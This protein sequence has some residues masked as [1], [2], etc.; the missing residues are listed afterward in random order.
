MSSRVLL[1]IPAYNCEKQI[2]RVL[3]QV[4]AEWCQSVVGR[5]IVV[6]NRST[7]RTGEVVADHIRARGDN[8]VQLLLNNEN[9]GLGGSHK[10]A[11][12]YAVQEGYDWLV[13]LHGDDQGSVADFRSVLLQ[14]DSLRE[15]AV[16]GS[17]FMS[18]SQTP[19]YSRFRIFGN[20]LF[21]LLYSLC[22]FRPIRDLGAGLNLYRVSSLKD[23]SF[24]NYPDNLTFNCVMVC[25]QAISGDQ[26]LFEPI[27]WR[28]DD[29]I[30][31]VKMVRQSIQT[32]KIALSALFQ[33]R[34]FLKR[35]H[36]SK[37]VNNYG[38]QVIDV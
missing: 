13:V 28:E 37:A 26:L 34:S 8:Y 16:L 18:G 30:S 35:D 15:D 27:S 38:W 11:F 3:A 31:N 19:G 5:V 23:K 32:L 29:Q 7:D 1:F 12:Q 6:N 20:H 36:R 2:G 21:N 14:R 25:A 33:R 22:V 9:Y 17:R 10:V 4:E 24:Q